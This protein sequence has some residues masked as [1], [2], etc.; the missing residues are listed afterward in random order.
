MLHLLNIALHSDLERR[1][2][3]CH[4]NHLL[5]C[6]SSGK[7]RCTFTQVLYLCTFTQVNILVVFL[8]CAT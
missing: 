1:D 2:T 6:L 8:L 5:Y 3:V 4:I 7:S